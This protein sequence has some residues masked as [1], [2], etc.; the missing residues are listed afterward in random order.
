MLVG[1]YLN[2]YLV[3]LIIGQSTPPTLLYTFRK[4]YECNGYDQLKPDYIFGTPTTKA[5][6]N[7]ANLT[8]MVVYCTENRTIFD[9]LSRNL[10]SS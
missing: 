6:N 8:S 7:V 10:S 2:Y 3:E 5:S 1:G 9:Y 4:Y